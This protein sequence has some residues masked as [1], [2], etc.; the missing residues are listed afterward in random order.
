MI[1]SKNKV[2]LITPDQRR[3]CDFGHANG[4]LRVGRSTQGGLLSDQKP[5]IL[6]THVLNVFDSTG[7][8]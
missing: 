4:L 8:T 2:I 7:L 3:W 5:D 1:R 6:V